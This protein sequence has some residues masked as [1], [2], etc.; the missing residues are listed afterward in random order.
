MV[1]TMKTMDKKGKNIVLRTDDLRIQTYVASP[2]DLFT[3][4]QIMAK[5]A[6]HLGETAEFV[7]DDESLERLVRVRRW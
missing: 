7:I 3:T 4:M 6:R 2:K 1:I 5:D